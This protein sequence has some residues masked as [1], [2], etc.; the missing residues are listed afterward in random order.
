MSSGDQYKIF[1]DAFRNAILGNVNLQRISTGHLWTE[2]PVWFPSHNCLLF[3]DIPNEKIY[4]W[5]PDGVV[6]IFRDKSNYAN[7]H[8]RDLD[9]RLVSC[10][11]GSR[12]LTRTEHDGTITT[13]A[14][15]YDGKKLN[16]P[17]DVVVKSDGTIWFTD[18]TYGILSNYEGYKSD[19]DQAANYVFCLNPKNDELLPVA[20]KFNQPNG[21]AFS[22]DE[23][24]LYVAESG[25]SHDPNVETVLRVFG[26]NEDNTLGNG[27]VFAEITLGIPDGLRIDTEGRIWV[28]GADGVNCY[29]PEGVL[30]GKILVPEV[31]SNLT[32]GGPRGN[33]LFITA[34]T[35]V[36]M[37]HVNASSANGR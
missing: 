37:I 9:G 23:K 5:F 25:N 33:I 30:L 2:G 21:I 29:S 15:S 19:R 24:L 32:F 28:S 10:Q 3:S 34:T 35:S 6:S 36:Y 26:V 4:R 16:S 13:L 31:V 17:N 18:P 1:D 27:R 14:N 20:S 12:S 22:P 7:G 8:T 11:H